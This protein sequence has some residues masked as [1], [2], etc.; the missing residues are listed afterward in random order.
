MRGR[1]NHLLTIV[2]LDARTARSPSLKPPNR[3]ARH[4]GDDDRA[5]GAFFDL[6]GLVVVVTM[7][8]YIAGVH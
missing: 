8:G 2:D 7:I 5:S 3:P 4:S 1:V 6:L